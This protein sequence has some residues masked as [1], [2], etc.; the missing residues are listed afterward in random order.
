MLIA[1][2][3]PTAYLKLMQ[4]ANSR[5]FIATTTEIYVTPGFRVVVTS[6]V[7]KGYLEG[8]A[9]EGNLLLIISKPSI[10]RLHLIQI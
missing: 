2:S 1:R 4:R 5:Q 9:S 7:Y 8:Y 6:L 10:I 3:C